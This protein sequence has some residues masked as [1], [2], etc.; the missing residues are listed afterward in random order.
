MKPVL[1]FPCILVSISI[2]DF[3]SDRS[4]L[5]GVMSSSIYDILDYTVNSDESVL[6]DATLRESRSPVALSKAYPQVYMVYLLS[7]LNISGSVRVGL[8]YIEILEVGVG[9]LL[10]CWGVDK[11]LHSNFFWDVIQ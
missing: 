10:C 5:W 1:M 3:I 11:F 7:S 6:T 4:S 2:M 9:G 8:L